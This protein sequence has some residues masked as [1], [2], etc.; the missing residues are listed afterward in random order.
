MRYSIEPKERIYVKRYEFCLLLGK[1][2]SINYGQELLDSTKKSTT[3][4]TK[5]TSKKQFKK[6]QKQLMI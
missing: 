2:L 4:V 1:S 3:D 6:Q 5:T